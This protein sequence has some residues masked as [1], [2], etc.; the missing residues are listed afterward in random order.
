MRKTTSDISSTQC[1][2]VNSRVYCNKALSLNTRS[3]F[4]GAKTRSN[5]PRTMTLTGLRSRNFS[6][7]SPNIIPLAPGTRHFCGAFPASLYQSKTAELTEDSHL[8]RDARAA[9]HHC[10]SAAD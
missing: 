4:S 7:H 1:A 5:I 3:N 6:K 2:K 10:G 8:Y 9:L